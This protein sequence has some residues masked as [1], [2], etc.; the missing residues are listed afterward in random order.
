MI[1]QT[2]TLMVNETF[3]SIQGEG[4]RIGAPAL[5]I[6]LDKC[7]LR[8]SWCDTPYA[9]AGD[10]G[11]E[12][13][14]EELRVAAGS[15]RNVVITGGEPLL[16]DIRPLVAVLADRHVTV[17]TS[18]TIFADLPAVSLFSISP[19]VGTS[20]Y[21]PK[22]SVLRKYCAT[23]AARMQLKFVIGEPGD[24]EE[25]VA[26]IRQL[27]GAPLAMPIIFQPESTRAGSS[28]SYLNFLEQLTQAVLA[29]AELRPYDVRVLP[30]LHYLLWNGAPG[31]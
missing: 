23:A 12:R 22:L 2:A 20:G 3:V 5:F 7:P 29:R 18:G 10:A 9:L 11:V 17:E 8:C 28:A 14:V 21:S 13:S 19:K 25:A 26:C 1:T 6:R 31:R 24:F 4:E 27:G 30:Q 15:L 16:Q